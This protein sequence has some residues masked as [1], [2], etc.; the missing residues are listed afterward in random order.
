MLEK[1]ILEIDAAQKNRLTDVTISKNRLS[2]KDGPP[3]KSNGLYWIYTDHTDLELLQSTSSSQRGALNFSSLV[4]RNRSGNHCCKEAV[5]GYRIV[6]SG[7]GGVGQKNEGG[8]R[9]RILQEFRGGEGTGSLAIAKS[10]VL[11]FSRWKVSFVLWDEI[12]ALRERYSYYPFA[13]AVEGLWRL[14]FGWPMLCSK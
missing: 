7:I 13:T 14:H 10:S 1:L 12:D 5:D 4:E 11:D 9:E 3:T 8:L 2:F 6:Y